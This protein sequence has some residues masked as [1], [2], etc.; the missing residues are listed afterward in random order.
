MEHVCKQTNNRYNHENRIQAPVLVPKITLLSVPRRMAIALVCIL[1]LVCAGPAMAHEIV[2]KPV[3]T[4]VKIG[5]KL[6]FSIHSAHVFI[7]SEELE[8]PHDVKA[9]FLDN[10][11]P[12]EVPLTAD[13]KKF[14]F[15]GEAVFTTPGTKMLLV[16]R[17]GQVWSLTPEGMKKGTKKELPGSTMSNRYEKF[18]KALIVVGAADDGFKK[19]IGDKLEIVPVDDPTKAEVGQDVTFKIFYNG[20]PLSTAVYA[21]Y[22][23]FTNTPNTYA[24]FTESDDKGTARVKI[25]ASGLW[26]VRVENKTQAPDGD[27]IDQEFIRSTLVFGVK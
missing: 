8:D 17:L 9:Y 10:D 14:T 20:Q 4:E 22:D 21:T 13:E 23:G 18:A 24:Y 5:E 19:P 15:D 11:T 16:H 7:V 12:M 1:V 3:K 27:G 26:M 2:I 6:P 25:T